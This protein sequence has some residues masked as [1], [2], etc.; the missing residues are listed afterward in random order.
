MQW[1]D[2]PLCT[3]SVQQQTLTI[4]ENGILNTESMDKAA[5]EI[6]TNR[7]VR[8]DKERKA[9]AELQ[10]AVN[11]EHKALE[12]KISQSKRWDTHGRYGYLPTEASKPSKQQKLES[13]VQK[14][15]RTSSNDDKTSTSMNRASLSALT[16][17]TETKSSQRRSRVKCEGNTRH[18]G[19]TGIRMSNNNVDEVVAKE[20]AVEQT[21][22]LT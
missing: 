2:G 8:A 16:V 20:Y 11:D 13:N 4:Y 10:E 15:K 14:L 7:N 1:T 17:V 18:S 21:F 3:E 22:E 6:P 5:H 12:G 9:T 19:K